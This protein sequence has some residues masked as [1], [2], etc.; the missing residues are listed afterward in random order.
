MS[1]IWFT[2]DTHFF[3]KQIIGYCSRPVPGWMNTAEKVD[4]M[5]DMM[6]VNWN[7][8]IAPQ[9]EVYHLGDFAFAGHT[10]VTPILDKLNG[11]KYLIRGNHD[12]EL[13]KK[14]EFVKRFQ[15]VR[16]YYELKVHDSYIDKNEKIV[17][18]HQRVVLM[19][20]PILSWHDIQHGSWHLHGHC[21]GSL[22]ESNLRRLDVGVDTNQLFPYEYEDV[23]KIMLT[24]GFTPVDHHGKDKLQSV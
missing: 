1:K 15:W 12:H 13:A 24:K 11:I 19:H 10:K 17:Q 18:Y 21:H 6:I 8:K 16:D 14:E 3:H 4:H 2:S 20:F 22:P 7:S 23:K 5:N 9:D